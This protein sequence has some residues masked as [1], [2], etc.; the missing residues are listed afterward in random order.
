[1]QIYYASEE[2]GVMDIRASGGYFHMAEVFQQQ[3]NYT[4]AKSLFRQV[5]YSSRL[6]LLL[7]V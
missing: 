7:L 1:M 2:F 3:H 4:V 5:D 6:L